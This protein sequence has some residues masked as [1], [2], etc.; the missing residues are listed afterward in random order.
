MVKAITTIIIRADSE[1]LVR[2]H[3][4]RYW[5]QHGSNAVS[6]LSPNY[7]SSILLKEDIPPHQ[8]QKVTGLSQTFN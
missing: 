4:K 7:C 6:K 3:V 2:N 5:E 8:P 1:D